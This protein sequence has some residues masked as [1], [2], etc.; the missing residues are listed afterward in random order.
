MVMSETEGL[1]SQIAVLEGNVREEQLQVNSAEIKFQQLNEELEAQSG[2]EA[3]MDDNL[4]TE[5]GALQEVADKKLKINE[6]KIT[7]LRTKYEE[8]SSKAR[9]YHMFFIQQPSYQ[10]IVALK[11]EL[12]SLQMEDDFTNDT[13]KQNVIDE[14]SEELASLQREVKEKKEQREE[15]MKELKINHSLM[16]ES[17]H[18]E[19]IQR[20]EMR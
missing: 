4:R 2:R 6:A 18:G 13:T 15:R 16:A 20:Y 11:A 12:A 17:Q 14:L 10:P 5:V 3:I 19:D 8:Y 1:L 9:S 7:N